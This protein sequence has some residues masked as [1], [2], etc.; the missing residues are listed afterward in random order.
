[1]IERAI[2]AA[3]RPAGGGNR[4]AAAASLESVVSQTHYNGF[5][6]LTPSPRRFSRDSEARASYRVRNPGVNG[7]T[8]QVLGSRRKPGLTSQGEGL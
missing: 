8:Q 3:G 5:R 6:C 1:M 4:P 7:D 2:A